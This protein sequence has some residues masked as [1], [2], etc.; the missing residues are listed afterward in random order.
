MTLWSTTF[1]ACGQ[2]V[3][4]NVEAVN[5]TPAGFSVVAAVKHAALNSTNVGFYVFADSG[6]VTNLD[7]QVGIEFYPLNSGNPQATNNYQTYQ[8]EVAL[9]QNAM[10]LGLIYARVSLCSP[11]TTYYYQI[12]V[13]NGNGHADFYPSNGPLPSVTTAVDNSFVLQS[14]QLLLTVNNFFPPGSIITLANS[15]TPSL[16]AAV[17]GDGANSDQVFFSL[18][19]L[20]A[21]AG[22]TNFAPLGTQVFTASIL[23][24]SS[25]ALTQSYSVPFTTNFLVGQYAAGALGPLATAIAIGTGA[26][27]TGGTGA[28]P[29]T[30]NAQSAVV[31]LS[32][33]LRFPTNLFTAIS[34]Q[35]SIAAVGAASVNPLSSNS[36]LLNLSAATGNNLLGSQQV[37]QLNLTA[38]SNQ[39]SAFVP[40]QPQS[41]AGTNSDASLAADFSLQGGRA[42]IIGRQSLLDMQ[43]A[44]GGANLTLYGIPGDTYEVQSSTNIAQGWA[45]FALVPM[46]GLSQAFDL[47]H[48]SAPE[49]FFRAYSFNADPPIIQVVPGEA[50]RTL[51]AYGV[52]GTNYTLQS[53]GSLPGVW[54]PV[55]T[56]TLTNSF[57]YLTNLG[58]SSQIFYRLKR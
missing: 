15:N 23:A 4:T 43:R 53:A 31:G 28:I 50:Q 38:A 27:L 20:I 48:P 45:N 16:L 44:G 49:A 6:G 24:Q 7:G 35:P 13:S 1:L 42:V 17:V 25:N 3:F 41:P 11:G 14:R 9:R 47:V 57:L 30:L 10:G 32:F 19:D 8:S 18:N 22:G 5:V 54:S 29:I 39:P 46:S 37:A 58:N 52:P 56:Y 12:A 51:L 26:M 21:A 36:V 34:V 55:T 33:V 40:L 2:T